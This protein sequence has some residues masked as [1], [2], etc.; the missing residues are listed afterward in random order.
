MDGARRVFEGWEGEKDGQMYSLFNTQSFFV[1]RGLMADLVLNGKWKRFCNILIY[2]GL[3]RIYQRCRCQ[4][5]TDS[6][7][8]IVFCVSAPKSEVAQS[9]WQ[10]GY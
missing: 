8:V 6:K 7:P 4:Q 9:N 5:S 10:L 3:D 1:L 2:Q